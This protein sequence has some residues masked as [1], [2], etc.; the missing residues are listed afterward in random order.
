[1]PIGDRFKRELEKVLT[2]IEYG[3]EWAEDIEN[4]TARI[5]AKETLAHQLSCF[6]VQTGPLKDGCG[7]SDCILFMYDDS[8]RLHSRS[9]LRRK[10]LA[11]VREELRI[12][13]RLK[14]GKGLKGKGKHYAPAV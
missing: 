13:R 2:L 10:T 8:G 1:M 12:W 6:L 7:T 4:E 3:Y 11:F 14:T 9:L 5:L